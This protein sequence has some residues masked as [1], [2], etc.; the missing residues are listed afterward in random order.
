[1]VRP[2]KPRGY[3]SALNFIALEFGLNGRGRL[4]AEERPSVLQELAK[5]RL[6]LEEQVIAPLQGHEPC[7]RDPGGHAATG[8]GRTAWR[9]AAA[10]EQR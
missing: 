7:A 8:L 2:L 6:V 3:N 1:M 5:G 10:L 4:G 9:S